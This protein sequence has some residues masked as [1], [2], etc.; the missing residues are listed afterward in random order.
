MQ[1]RWLSW[2]G[3]C[4]SA[5][6]VFITV[7]HQILDNV[8]TGDKMG[9]SYSTRRGDEVLVISVGKSEGKP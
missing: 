2:R 6:R 5:L 4:G 7:D 1:G 3:I 9:G 8:I